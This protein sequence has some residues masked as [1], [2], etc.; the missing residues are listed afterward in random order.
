M[1]I[2]R[3]CFITSSSLFLTQK[4]KCINRR[5]K[6]YF[7][8]QPE[9]DNVLQ[10]SCYTEKIVISSLLYPFRLRYNHRTVFQRAC[11]AVIPFQ[12]GNDVIAGLKIVL[13][14][15]VT[16]TKQPQAIFESLAEGLPFQPVQP[17]VTKTNSK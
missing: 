1:K 2:R 3:A 16:K 4:F 13:Q 8:V 14:P 11:L 10:R 5:I 6:H 15:C 17:C 7:R 9:C 12:S